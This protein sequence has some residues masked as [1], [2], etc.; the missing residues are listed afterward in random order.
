M[1]TL[2]M[3]ALACGSGSVAPTWFE[4]LYFAVLF[5]VVVIASVVA[6]GPRQL[7]QSAVGRIIL[8]GC[9]LA[10]ALARNPSYH[11]PAA[12]ITANNSIS[13]EIIS[14]IGCI[15]MWVLGVK[16]PFLA[17]ERGQSGAEKLE[18]LL[19]L[20]GT[21]LQLTIAAM[22][23][24]PVMAALSGM[25]LQSALWSTVFAGALMLA[26]H[27]L[28][29]VAS[30]SR[31]AQLLCILI[32]MMSGF[33]IALGLNAYFK[34]R[35]EADSAVVHASTGR[36][37]LAQTSYESALR[38]TQAFRANGPRID[39]ETRL[40]QQYE[41]MN[42]PVSALAHW[43]NVVTLTK[44]D[45]NSFPPI[46]RVRCA[47]GDSV[48]PWRLLVFEGIPAIANPDM[49]PG[50][51]RLV[52]TAP[53]VRAKLL[54]ALLAWDQQAPDD[55][56]RKRLEAVQAVAPGEPT[57]L[58]LLKRMNV[59]TKDVPL[60][61]PADLIIGTVPTYQSAL[62]TIE[63]LGE[64]CT[65]VCLNA[66]RWEMSLNASGTPLHEEWPVVR[67]ELNGKPLAATQVN[68]ALPYDVPFTF[69]V[70]HNTIFKVR[71]VFQNRQDDL[72]DGR[73][74]RRGL[75]IMGIKFNQAK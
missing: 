12:G 10:G 29:A 74:A 39:M 55:E 7:G 75:K 54:G 26:L 53:D 71:I 44:A 18:A 16:L 25:P 11:L 3:F 9:A 66:G 52:D 23:A 50:V 73:A 17:R 72:E 61:L 15:L 2:A 13:F 33:T 14:L 45:K 70:T 63:E 67:V 6:G 8:V 40:A 62:G 51:M 59:P 42:N 38:L 28:F 46:R 57:S 24:L 58:S 56:R 27:G 35:S 49:A 20:P 19:V 36:F 21:R 43:E 64:A 32:L 47:M 65:I 69:D 30:N 22:I 68:K 5:C 60:W 4:T 37:D 34:L 48:P 1:L 41:K 31:C